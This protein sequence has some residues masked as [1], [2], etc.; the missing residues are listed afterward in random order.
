MLQLM[1]EPNTGM[2]LPSMEST[3]HQLHHLE[4]PTLV[5]PRP[6]SPPKERKGPVIKPKSLQVQMLLKES[7]TA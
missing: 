4:K 3:L 1:S 6:A 7:Q 2:C 5:S